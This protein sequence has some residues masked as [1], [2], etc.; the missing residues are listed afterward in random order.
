L[1]HLVKIFQQFLRIEKSV[2]K[3]FCSS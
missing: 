1:E 2:R 3:T